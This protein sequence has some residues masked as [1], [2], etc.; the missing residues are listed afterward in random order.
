MLERAQDGL[1][2]CSFSLRK[3]MEML[4]I[5]HSLYK[6]TEAAAEGALQKKMLL[7]IS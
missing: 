3:Y 6:H 2:H 4:N 1:D 5:F 7:K